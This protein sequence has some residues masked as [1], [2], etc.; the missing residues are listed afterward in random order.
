MT[1]DE[2][3]EEVLEVLRVIIRDGLHYDVAN[4]RDYAA[5]I[6][7]TPFGKALIRAHWMLNSRC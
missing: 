3:A 1:E 2:W 6:K 7:D 5:S 4:L